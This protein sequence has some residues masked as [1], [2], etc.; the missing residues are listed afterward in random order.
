MD[1]RV[2][3]AG[4]RGDADKPAVDR[5]YPQ[6]TVQAVAAAPTDFGL[7]KMDRRCNYSSVDPGHARSSHSLSMHHYP[8]RDPYFLGGPCGMPLYLG[9]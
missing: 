9:I 5:R 7:L 2:G 6:R 8:A 4:V 1:V 3:A